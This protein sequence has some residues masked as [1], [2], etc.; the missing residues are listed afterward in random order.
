MLGELPDELSGKAITQFVSTGPNLIVLNMV[1]IN[2][3]QLLK[4][5][6]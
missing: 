4:D 2:K 6:H 1:T 3:I 5:L